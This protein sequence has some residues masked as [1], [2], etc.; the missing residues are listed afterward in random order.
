[1]Y[2]AQTVY[3][4][5]PQ[6]PSL[7]VVDRPTIGVVTD[8]VKAGAA[9]MVDPRNPLFWFGVVLLATVGAAG[10]A[11]SARLGPARVAASIGKG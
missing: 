8:D 6:A 11:G 9:G 7:A 2:D 1:M 4:A 3:G 5:T 10:V